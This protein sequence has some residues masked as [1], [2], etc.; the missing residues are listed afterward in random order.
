MRL[1]SWSLCRTS[2][3]LVAP[4]AGEQV[5]RQKQMSPTQCSTGG[6]EEGLDPSGPEGRAVR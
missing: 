1:Q 6:E 4:T 2:I 5:R 3:P